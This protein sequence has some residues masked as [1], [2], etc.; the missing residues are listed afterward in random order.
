MIGPSFRG[1]A[2]SWEERGSETSPRF[3]DHDFP[4]KPGRWHEDM[5]AG[6]RVFTFVGFIVS[7]SRDV[8]RARLRRLQEACADQRPGTLMHP[9][10]GA[11]R[12]VCTGFK[13]KETIAKGGRIDL[14]LT[15]EEDA[16]AQYPI[17]GR[18]IGAAL[19][20][21]VAGARAS[22]AAAF[23]QRW[24]LVGMP[25]YITGEASSGL[26]DL[27]L[28]VSDTLGLLTPAVRSRVNSRAKGLSELTAISA[29]LSVPLVSL[30]EGYTTDDYGRPLVLNG[31]QAAA[32]ASALRPLSLYRLPSQRRSRTFARAVGAMALEAL[33][34]S[35]RWLALIEEANVSRQLAFTSA[36]EAIT[37]RDAL[38]DRLDVEILAAADQASN[39][40]NE[41]IARASDALGSVRTEMISDLT[42]RAASL[43]PVAHISLKQVRPAIALAY[44]LYGDGDASAGDRAKT[45]ALAEDLGPRN[46][47]RDPG[48]LP[49]G[50]QLEYQAG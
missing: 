1:V 16:G 48:M 21:A 2:W 26:A 15:F 35:V 24:N 10:F 45:L 22:T 9:V 41:V 5:A 38:A 47:V 27:A 12:A 43:K 44:A 29:G 17:A 19:G 40:G 7:L 13:S 34:S 28:T 20:D 23:D 39:D 3:V 11:I 14:D 4:Q 36:D 49:G 33:A 31:P 50:V 46:R 42:E 6:P 32:T 8:A 18:W 37:T 30:F 25:S